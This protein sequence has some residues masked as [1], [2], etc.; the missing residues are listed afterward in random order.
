MKPPEPYE[1]RSNDRLFFVGKTGAGKTAAVKKLVWQPL[2]RVIFADIKGREYRD[3]N[4]PVLRSLDDVEVA[5]HADDPDDRL[6]KFVFRP[7]R[8]DVD[9]WD[10]L[11]RLVYQKGNHHLIGDEL[12]SVYHGRGLSEHHNLL[13]TNGRDKGVGFTGTTQRPM[14]VPREAVSEAEHIFIFKL[15]DPDDQDRVAKVTAGELPTEPVN[16]PH[17]KYIY[18]H[19]GLEEPE[20][21]EPLDI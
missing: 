8:I 14:R 18:E 6:D 19:D 12:K 7:E 3:L 10:E 20:E 1:I 2:D 9:E 21:N 13:L 15:K 11:C 4:Q 5:L 17:Y 16:L